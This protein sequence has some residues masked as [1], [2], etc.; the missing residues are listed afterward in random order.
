MLINLDFPVTSSM[1]ESKCH[2]ECFAC[3]NAC[4]HKVLK[5][6]QWNINTKRTEII[7]YQLCNQKRSLY[8]KTH[9]RKH[10]CGYCMVSCPCG[11]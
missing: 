10:S 8:I 9:N 5:G 3:V 4:P 6:K 1:L 11:L 2:K 7:D